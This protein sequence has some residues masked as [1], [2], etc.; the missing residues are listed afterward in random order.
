MSVK[1]FIK[2]VVSNLQPAVKA[3]VEKPVVKPVIVDGELVDIE[4]HGMVGFQSEAEKKFYIESMVYLTK[5][6]SSSRFKKE[7]MALKVSETNGKN[8]ARVYQEIINGW[9]Q[10]FK[11]DDGDLDIFITLYTGGSRGTVG[12]SYGKLKIWTSRNFFNG[13]FKR[14]DHASLAAHTFH[15]H[16]HCMGYSHRYRH[17]GTLVYDAG[18]LVGNLVRLIKRGDEF[19]PAFLFSDSDYEYPVFSLI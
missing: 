11:K 13:W 9:C 16:L 18:Y 10:Y 15:E 12:Y 2:S 6:L 4:I 3:E 1:Q 17:Q 19:R 7:F 14:G 8:L 5:C